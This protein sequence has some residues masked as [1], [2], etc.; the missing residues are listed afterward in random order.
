MPIVRDAKG[1]RTFIPNQ[2]ERTRLSKAI[3]TCAD[4]M[5]FGATDAIKDKGHE[6][7]SALLLL[8]EFLTPTPKEEEDIDTGHGEDI[9]L[10]EPVLT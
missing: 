5:D 1:A 3:G 6:A 7:L 10:E 8:V 4:A 9:P 2:L